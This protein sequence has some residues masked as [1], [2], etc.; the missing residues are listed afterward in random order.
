MFVAIVGTPSSG[1]RSVLNYFLAKGFTHVVIGQDVHTTE[2]TELSSSKP[3]YTHVP[4]AARPD[5]AQHFASTPELLNFATR[6][7]RSNFVTTSLQTRKDIDAFARRPFFLLLGVDAP[8]MTRWRR[9][10][11]KNPNDLD[12]HIKLEDFVVESDAHLF[13]HPGS[14]TEGTAAPASLHDTLQSTRHVSILNPYGTQKD[15]HHHLDSLDLLN[16]ERLR[17]SWD[18]YFMTLSE[19]AAQRCNCMKRRVGA[20]LVRNNRIVATGYNGTPR[21]LK[22]CNEGG[23]PRCNGEARS[24]QALDECLCLHAEENALLEAGRERVGDGAVLYCNTCPC[25]RCAV[26]IIQ[27]GVKEVVYNFA[28]SMD[29][30]TARVLKEAGVRLRQHSP[31]GN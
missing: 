27:T 31:P 12:D 21:G 16:E 3:R 1:K 22:N 13:G 19:L 5:T 4:N 2:E 14:D 25:L 30:A 26:K 11:A 28:Y 7:W 17:P 8:V 23:C 9:H 6:T 10:A 15:L 24:G 20:I 29:E 18:S